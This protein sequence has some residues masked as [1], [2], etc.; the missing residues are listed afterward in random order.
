MI[1][2]PREMMSFINPRRKLDGLWMIQIV[3]LEA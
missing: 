2:A 3:M 1:A